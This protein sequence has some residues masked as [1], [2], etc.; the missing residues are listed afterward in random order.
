[1]MECVVDTGSSRYVASR[2]QIM[3][4]V[5]AVNMPYMKSCGALANV[6]VLAMPPAMVLVTCPPSSS[7]PRNSKTAA[8][9][10]A[11]HMVCWRVVVVV[12]VVG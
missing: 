7:A 2:I 11:L 8:I 3:A 6:E 4:P 5:S 9:Q 12:V 1:M 10:T